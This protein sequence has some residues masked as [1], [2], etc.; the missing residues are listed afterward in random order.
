VTGSGQRYLVGLIGTGIME[1]LSP[2]LHERE[3]DQ[4]GVRYLYRKLDMDMLGIAAAEVG[5]VVGEAQRLGFTGLNITHPCKQLVIPALD[6]LAPEAAQIGAVNTITFGADGATGHNTDMFGFR[7]NFI[8]GLPGADTGEVVLLGAGG[9]GAAV[10]Y[11]LLSLGAG[12]VTIYDLAAEP[13]RS[14]ALALQSRFGAER[15]RSVLTNQLDLAVSNAHGVVNATPIGMTAHPGMPIERG[16]LAAHHWVADVVYRPLETE[17]LRAARGKGC[18]VLD[19]GGMAVFQALEA[20]R[21]FTGRHP[22]SG[23]MLAHFKELI[24]AENLEAGSPRRA[25]GEVT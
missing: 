9:A 16:L 6:R 17:L 4:L 8:R 5:T 18:R 7:E 11:A 3:A 12:R 13:A 21:L 10:A 1:S 22:D 23:R 20:F 19:G 14:L 15:A 25:P 2:A 24:V